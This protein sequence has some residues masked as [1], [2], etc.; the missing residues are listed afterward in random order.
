MVGTNG[1]AFFVWSDEEKK[2]FKIGW[3]M[4]TL[5][6]KDS[7]RFERIGLHPSGEKSCCVCLHFLTQIAEW[8]S[9]LK[10]GILPTNVLII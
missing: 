2:V 5:V 8:D 4:S 1:L 7:L 9:F 10:R 3:L 6:S